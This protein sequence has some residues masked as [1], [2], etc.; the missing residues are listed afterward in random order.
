MSEDFD[1]G[2]QATEPCADC[3]YPVCECCCDVEQCEDCGCEVSF[4]NMV[5]GRCRSCDWED[6]NC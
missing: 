4:V 1:M 3:G 2:V 5:D 6:R